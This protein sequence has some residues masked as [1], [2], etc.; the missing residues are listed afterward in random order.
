MGFSLSQVQT[1]SA[2]EPMTTFVLCNECGNR[3]KVCIFLSLHPLPRHP[4]MLPH[5]RS[6][7]LTA[8]KGPCAQGLTS[9]YRVGLQSWRSWRVAGG[10]AG[11]ECRC[12]FSFGKAPGWDGGSSPHFI[13]GRASSSFEHRGNQ[14]LPTP[15]SRS[16][17]EKQQH[18]AFGP[19]LFTKYFNRCYFL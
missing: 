14:S 11:K 18:S 1:R 6:S 16:T 2:D 17:E 4:Q 3:W 9:L 19:H 10:E 5:I 13:R 8:E 15:S 7:V 12:M